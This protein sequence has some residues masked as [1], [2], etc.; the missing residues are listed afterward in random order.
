MQERCL[1]EEIPGATNDPAMWCLPQELCSVW[2]F[3]EVAKTHASQ[4]HD[5]LTGISIINT[6]ETLQA[7]DSN[8]RW[9]RDYW[10][11]A[12]LRASWDL[13]FSSPHHL[14][15]D[16]SNFLYNPKDLFWNL[17]SHSYRGQ[18]FTQSFGAWTNF[19]S[20]NR[21]TTS[22]LQQV[23]CSDLKDPPK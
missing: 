4:R 17:G 10:N 11:T 14:F 8:E 13:C 20:H 18:T 7:T 16:S 6:R 19:S 15:L 2:Q 9:M 23:Y 22:S 12:K 21:S 1:H 5:S 3:L